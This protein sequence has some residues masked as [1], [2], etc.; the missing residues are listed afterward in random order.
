M[1][2]EPGQH[3]ESCK[4]VFALLSAY[5]DAE[6]PAQTC[7]EIQAHLVETDGVDEVAIISPPNN[8]PKINQAEKLGK[9]QRS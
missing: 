2:H 7:E 1:P 9:S 5:L 6:L 3:S 4:E 8:K